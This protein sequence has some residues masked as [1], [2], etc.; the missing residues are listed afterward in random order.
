MK[1]ISKGI[2]ATNIKNKLWL[3]V[4]VLIFVSC[5]KDVVNYAV[6]S[7]FLPYERITLITKASEVSI[8][9]DESNKSF[10]SS[11]GLEVPTGHIN[12]I[13]SKDDENNYY[14][15]EILK[16]P[17]SCI[18]IESSNEKASVLMGDKVLNSFIYDDGNVQ[19]V[20]P[21]ASSKLKIVLQI[22]CYVAL[23]ILTIITFYALCFAHERVCGD[24]HLLL[25]KKWPF[26]ISMWVML[27]AMLVIQYKS[28]L[29]LPHYVPDN[30]YGDQA[31]YWGTYIFSNYGFNYDILAK[32]QIF[33][34]YLCYFLP[35][36]AQFIGMR[37]NVDPVVIYMLFPS[38]M[39]SWLCVV[40]MPEAYLFFSH[41]KPHIFQVVFVMIIICVYWNDIII[42]VLSDLYAGVLFLSVIY[43]LY[44]YSTGK[45]IVSLVIAAICMAATLQYRMQYI[46]GFFVLFVGLLLYLW[47]KRFGKNASFVY[48]FSRRFIVHLIVA[49]LAFCTV[50]VPQARTNYARGHI[51]LFPYDSEH[52]YCDYPVVWSYWNVFFAYGMVMVPRF[53]SDGQIVSMKT[54]MG[55]DRMQEITPAQAMDCYSNNPIDF[56]V[57]MIKKLFIGFDKK[58][59]VNYADVALWRFTPG[60]LFSFFNYCILAMGLYSFVYS[61]SNSEKRFLGIIFCGTILPCLQAHCE[62]RYFLIGYI[63]LYYIFAFSSFEVIKKAEISKRYVVTRFL[64][65]FVLISFFISYTMW[66]A[67]S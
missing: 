67:I 50:C 58:T 60:M 9:A 55:Y 23:V 44:R 25:E 27:F 16:S 54:D 45:R 40:L 48:L 20:Y 47:K 7:I 38:F 59:S 13:D 66:G 10:Y 56:V 34:G 5:F 64:A 36:V 41:K 29:R 18:V 17:T 57:V 30:A 61:I 33:R 63:I 62:W 51:G 21:F 6:N 22:C 19:K 11:F 53:V 8:S 1:G 28:G 26:F 37:L 31:G 52:A 32:Q 49:M 42:G 24:S 2:C 4:L 46:I 12:S 3:F 39:V 35:S 14:D 65:V 15:I 43:F